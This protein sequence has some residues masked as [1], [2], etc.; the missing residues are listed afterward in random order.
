MKKTIAQKRASQR[1][2]TAKQR[3]GYKVTLK[4]LGVNSSEKLL[5]I[6]GS[7]SDAELFILRTMLEKTEEPPATKRATLPVSR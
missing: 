3:A 5:G 6:L 4:K 2:R 7:M 1:R